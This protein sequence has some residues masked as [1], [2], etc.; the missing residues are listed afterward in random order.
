M[1]KK[2]SWVVM[3]W[4]ITMSLSMTSKHFLNTSHDS[5][6]I[7]S[8]GTLFQC[9][10][11]LP[12][13]YFLTSN[14]NL[15]WCY[16]RRFHFILSLLPGRRGQHPPHHNLHQDVVASNKAPGPGEGGL[17][18]GVDA[19]IPRSAPSDPSRPVPSRPVEA[20]RPSAMP[21]PCPRGALPGAFLFFFLL[22]VVPL[23][24]TA[25]ALTATKPEVSLKEEAAKGFL[26]SLRRPRRQ[27]WDRSQPDVQQWYQQFLY[28]GFDEAKF[29]DDM[30]YW[31]S[32]GRGGNE[33]YGGYYQHHYD[34]DSPIGP[35][36]PH[37]FRHGAG[38]NYDDY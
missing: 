25:P 21:P 10:T 4:T 3:E 11:T 8:L 38:V 7:T 31:T 34:E 28:L 9:M 5:D 30:S 6:S 19:A 17:D 36:N 2:H 33:Y 1:W 27:L 37:T 20:G 29:E 16:S 23:L 32:L 26:R 12:E 13:K 22:F 18:V 24:C 15:P 14:P 35:R